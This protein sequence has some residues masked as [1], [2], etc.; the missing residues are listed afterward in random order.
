[1]DK[2]KQSKTTLRLIGGF[3][4]LILTFV[5]FGLFAFYGMHTISSLTRTIYNH[6]LVV[7][8][9][10]LQSN[11]SIT[12]MHRSMKDVVLFSSQSE[13]SHTIKVINEHE[14]QAY[15]YL[16]IVKEQII[17]NEGKML[18]IEARILFDNWRPIREEVIELVQQGEKVTAA[19][20][21]IGKGANHV[22]LLEEKMLGLTTYARNKASDFMH[23]NDKAHS[24]IDVALILFLLFGTL[25]SFLIAFFT[26][27]RITLAEVTLKE[28]E[29][30]FR[31]MAATANDAIIIM[32]N[33]KNISYLNS[34]AEEMLGYDIQEVIGKDL[35]LLL[36]PEKYYDA[37]RKGFN[38]F[39]KKGEGGAVGKTLELEAVRKDGTEFPI[40]LSM[41]GC[42]LKGQWHAVGIMR[43]ITERK[44]MEK[45]LKR[46]SYLDGLTGVANRRRFDEALGLEWRRMTRVAKPLS[47]IIC[48]IDFFKEYND[49]YGHQGGDESLRLVANTIDS[50]S[51]RPGDL[52]ARYGG[53]EFAVI[54]P[55][56]DSQ[57]AQFI[58]E[59][60][61]S[62]VESLGVRNV[63]SQVCEVLTISLGVATTIPTSGSLPDELISA[64][65]QALYE[66]KKGGRNRV[67]FAE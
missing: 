28:S 67:N 8:N 63:S 48:D 54:L 65:D 36:A 15:H 61:R 34:T 31:V 50:V 60:M 2:P 17:D 19:G 47:L 6:P 44:R 30:K 23:E 57:D 62:R 16:D 12:R 38:E 55:E 20:I 41:S 52:V 32:D 64:A 7:S 9:A 4:I 18:E 45:E 46:L 42:Q 14:K 40:E 35:H 5:L 66:A 11:L 51:G 10:T 21:T 39:R 37:F 25:T 33:N 49:T 56:T 59:K 58:A 29:E 26:I 13:I 53:E 43:D 22:A 24:R 3:G 27:K 1:M